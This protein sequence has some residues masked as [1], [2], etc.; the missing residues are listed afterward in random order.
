[1]RPRLLGTV[2][3]L[4]AALALA[5]P[6]AAAAEPAEAIEAGWWWRL[7]PSA[8]LPPPPSP[9]GDG[10]LVQG[11][12]DGPVAVAAVRAAL[13]TA[14]AGPVL[15]LRVAPGFEQASDGAV[16]V[17]CPAASAWKPDRAGAWD[18]RPQADCALAATGV[19]AADGSAFTF[20]LAGFPTPAGRLDV[21]LAPGRVAGAD[22]ANG[23]VFAVE[24]APPEPGDLR[25]TPGAAP[26][27]TPEALPGAAPAVDEPAAPSASDGDLVP[28]LARIPGTID[29]GPAP[30]PGPSP[31][32][33]RRAP[34]RRDAV[35]E[36]AADLA[37]AHEAGRSA[38]ARAWGLAVLVAGV[39]AL[40]W[41]ASRPLP[42]PRRLVALGGRPPREGPTVTTPVTGGLGRFR[43]QRDRPPPRLV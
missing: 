37:A 16:I 19:R 26:A 9:A 21:V 7:R 29:L 1:M 31:P 22:G 2:M 36:R 27:P 35:R 40:A 15:T 3:P 28:E 17:A 39:A 18:Q 23:S 20:D 25:W 32:V 14:A 5:V 33:D 6:G 10:L 4:A 12:P 38:A 24:L 11:A 43:R 34:G 30:L 8:S 42:A 13:P 41:A